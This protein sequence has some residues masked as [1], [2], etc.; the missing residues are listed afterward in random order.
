MSTGTVNATNFNKD[1]TVRI[2]D[3]F[4]QYE[5]NIPAA[6]Y[7]VVFSYFQSTMKNDVV[8]GNFTVSLFRVAG[9]TGIPALT[10]L[11][12]FQGRTGVDLSATLAY[13]LNQI[14]DRATLLGV[15]VAI[16]PNFYAARN[17]IQ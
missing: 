13:Y 10:L 15:G 17:V 14:R 8:A 2:Y 4:Y 1:Q 11:S 5:D 16:V 6:E 3:Q 9:E 12:Q 7:D